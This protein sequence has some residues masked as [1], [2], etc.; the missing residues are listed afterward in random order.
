MQKNQLSLLE[1][2]AGNEWRKIGVKQ[3]HGVNIPLFSL[4]SQKSCGIG[5]FTDLSPLFPWCKAVG[6]DILQ[7]LPLNDTGRDQSPY[8][9]IS[10]NA[11]NPFHLGLASL[12]YLDQHPELQALLPDLQK[13]NKTERVDY[14][15][16]YSKRE[17]F[18]LK[19][20]DAIFPTIQQTPDYQTFWQQNSWL[21]GFALFKSIKISKDW[22]SWESWPEEIKNP[23]EESYSHL[24]KKFEKQIFFHSFVQFLCFQ[25]FHEIKKEANRQGIFIMGD[26]PILINYESADVWLN[27]S[28]FLTHFTAGA[29]PDMYSQEG[30]NWGFPIYNWEEMK[31]QDYHWWKK[32]MNVADRLYDLFRIDHIVGFF[33]IWAIPP[34]CTGREGLFLPED[35]NQWIPQGKAIMEIM[36]ANSC[37]LP[38]GEDLGVVPPEVRVCLSELGICGTRVMRWERNWNQDKSF[39][40]SENYPIDS[41]TTVST[42]DSETLTLW[43][44]ALP[45]EAKEYALFKGWLYEEILSREHLFEMLRD[46]HHTASLFHI[47]LLNEYLALM[48]ELIHPKP[49]EERIN[50]PGTISDTN[51][52]YRFRPSVEELVSNKELT[53]IIYALIH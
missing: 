10:A 53:D 17:D 11:L 15:N 28:I 51:W 19:Y 34:H 8:S 48:P 24:I 47:N 4:Y 33:R 21:E 29:P 36:L 42:H 16:L 13:F 37:M 14:K 43:W 41:L 27:R 12:P 49:E 1:T 2:K 46:S 45:E 35:N 3:H 18:L 20:F 32:R 6:F 40:K 25:Q 31:E 44:K 50:L 39:I 30:Q 7:L 23:T 38:I 9:A 52:S 5:E 22:E 26:I